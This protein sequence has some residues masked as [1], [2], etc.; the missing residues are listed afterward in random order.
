MIPFAVAIQELK[1]KLIRVEGWG[2]FETLGDV[3]EYLDA[4]RSEMA[5]IVKYHKE[6]VEELKQLSGLPLL[7]TDRYPA[8]KVPSAVRILNCLERGVS[9]SVKIYEY[10]IKLIDSWLLERKLRSSY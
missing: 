6:V 3:F 1:D 4:Q 5:T 2:T 8:F 7:P 9:D 10:E